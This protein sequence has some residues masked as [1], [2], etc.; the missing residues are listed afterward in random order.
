MLPSQQAAFLSSGGLFRRRNRGRWFFPR[1]WALLWLICLTLLAGSPNWPVS[2]ADPTFTPYYFGGA[3]ST[4]AVAVGDMNGDGRLDI[5]QGNDSYYGISLFLNDGLSTFGDATQVGDGYTLSAAVG[6]I[7]GDG[8]LDIVQGRDHAQNRVYLND[9]QGGFAA[10]IPFGSTPFTT[11]QSV[12]LGDFN[13][14]GALDI[15]EGNRGQSFLYLND[16][17]GGFGAGIPIG[18]PQDTRS[19]A[20]GDVNGDGALDIVMG[21]DNQPGMIYLND[22]LGGFGAGEPF[23]AVSHTARSV[24]VGDLNGDGALDIV[25]GNYGQQSFIYYNTGQGQFEVGVPLDVET[26]LTTSLVLGDVNGDGGLDIV[27][28]SE[29]VWNGQQWTEIK[30]ILYLNDGQGGFGAG[31]FIGEKQNARSLAVGDLNGDG[32]LDIVQGNSGQQSA[33]YVNLNQQDGFGIRFPLGGPSGSTLNLAV[34]D[35]NGDGALD[36]VVGDAWQINFYLNNQHG[37]FASGTGVSTAYL[38][39]IAIGDVNGDGALDIVQGNDYWED[40][41]HWL[42]IYSSPGI[43]Y[44]NTGQG[45]FVGSAFNP[46]MY[47]T[48]SIALGDLNGDDALDIV[49]GNRPYWSTTNEQWVGPASVINL[50]DGHSNFTASASFGWGKD[51][52]S[53]ALGDMNH[54]GALDIVQGN[55]GQP[56]VVYFND[57]QGRFE[58][59]LSFG[60]SY[61]TRSVAVGDLNGDGA[62]DIVQGNPWRQ[63]LIYWNSGWDPGQGQFERT[64]AFG[65][66]YDTRSI[67]IGDVNN[68]GAL[69]IVQGNYGSPSMIFLN[70]GLGGFG[71]GVSVGG[72]DKTVSLALGDLNGDGALDIVQGNEGQSYVYFNTRFR[73]AGLT[74]NPPAVTAT[75]PG[76]TR[77]AS[78]YSAPEIL[79][80]GIIPISYTLADPEGDAVG[81]VRAFYSLEGGGQWL[82]ARDA[83]SQPLTRCVSSNGLV[84]DWGFEEG[85]GALAADTSGNGYDLALNGPV[86]SD[87]T[88]ITLSYSAASLA[89]NNNTASSSVPTPQIDALQD[90][91]IALW[92]RPDTLPATGIARFITL[93]NEKAV[94]RSDHNEIHFYMNIGGDLRHLRVA[95]SLQPGVY[96][97]LAGSYD[98]TSRTMRLYYNGV[99]IASQSLAG[100][101]DGH[102]GDGSGVILG[103]FEEG[104]QGLVDEVRIYNRALLPDEI[105]ALVYNQDCAA[106]FPA[107]DAARLNRSLRF[108]GVDDFVALPDAAALHLADEMTIEAWV[109]LDDAGRDQKIV[110]KYVGSSGFILG[111]INGQLY[112][113]FADSA[114]VDY[115]FNAGE[116]GSIPSNE[117]T[118]LAVAWKTGDQIVAYIN[119]QAVYSTPA[120]ANPLAVNN[121]SI[122]I[123]A[124]SWMD[125][126]AGGQIDEVRLWSRALPAEEIAA[127]LRLGMPVNP[128]QM[129]GYWS[130]DEG[131]GSEVY[132]LSPQANHGLLAGGVRRP[133]WSGGAPLLPEG[134]VEASCRAVEKRWSL[135][136]QGDLPRFTLGSALN[137]DGVDDAV[138]VPDTAALNPTTFTI[139]AWI[140]ADTWAANNWEGTIVGKDGWS[141]GSRG[142]VL[143]SGDNGRLSAAVDCGGAWAGLGSLQLMTAGEWYH[144]AAAYNG[145]ELALFINGIPAG[146]IACTGSPIASSADLNI[147]RSPLSPDRLFAGQ[148]D[149]VRLWNYA[150]SAGQIRAAMR[151]A[152]PNATPGLIAS[153]RFNEGHGSAVFDQPPGKNYGTVVGATWESAA[154]PY[155]YY[156]DL[157]DGF[158]GQF[159]NIVFRLE[160]LPTSKAHAAVFPP[161]Y[162][163]SYSY[164]NSTPVFQHPSASATTFS[165]RMRGTQVRVMNG[166]SPAAGA[167][168]YR[169]EN[170]QTGR[171]QAIAPEAAFAGQAGPYLTDSQGYLLGRGE[172]LSGDQLT[173][174]WPAVVTDTYT[175]Y[176]TSAAPNDSGLEMFTLS[177]AGVQTLTV[178]SDNPLI[179]FNLDASLQWDARYDQ[180][181]LDQLERDFQRAAELLYDWTD[182]QAAL[183]SLRIYQNREHWNDAHIRIYASNELRPMAL[184]GGVV[185]SVISDTQNIKVAYAPGQVHLGAVWNRYGSAGSSLGE[186]WPRALAH[187]LGHYV[188]YLNDNYL[189]LA[190]G[191]VLLPVENCTGAMADPYREDLNYSEFHSQALW[192]DECSGTLSYQTTGRSDWETLTLFY[193]AL[194]SGGGLS[195]PNIL[196]IAVT[197]L[198]WVEPA[199]TSSPLTDPTFYLRQ[200]SEAGERLIPGAAARAFLFQQNWAID[201]GGVTQDHVL[202]R[203]AQPGD[204]LCVYDLPGQWA[205]CA[206]VSQFSEQIA[207]QKLDHWN[208]EVLITPVNSTTLQVSV[209]GVATENL[210]ASLYPFNE[211]LVLTRTLSTGVVT[212]HLA[213]P[214]WEGYLRI[215]DTANPAQQTIIDFAIGGNPSSIRG[216]SSSIR[217]S[218]SSIRGSSVPLLS[219]DGRVILFTDQTVL[220]ADQFY[221]LQAASSIPDPLSW[222]APV[223][224]VYRLAAAPASN[225]PDFSRAAISFGY[226]PLDVPGLAENR[227][228]LY[229]HPLNGGEWQLLP[230][231]VDEYNNM[232]SA[233]CQGQGWYALMSSREVSLP[234]AGW[235]LFA[236]SLERSLPVTDALRSLDGFYQ[237]IYGY[238]SLDV[239]DP[240][241]LHDVGV[242]SWVN[243][244]QTLEV[245]HG[246]WITVTQPVTLYLGY[247]DLAYTAALPNGD[248]PLGRVGW[249]GGEGVVNELPPATYYGALMGNGGFTP[250]A[251]MIIEAWVGAGGEAVFC[252]Q[253]VTQIVDGQVV[254]SIDVWAASASQPGCGQ[255]GRPVRFKVKD[256]AVILLIG[257]PVRS[258]LAWNNDRV[259]EV[260]LSPGYRIFLPAVSR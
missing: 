245:G 87:T 119:G 114:G 257:D 195:G 139:E 96:Q 187:E 226:N 35:V 188:F 227:L 176:Y 126:Y 160:A 104:Y 181:Y 158:F 209:S 16:K 83:I 29:S 69:D 72:N 133:R 153:W 2:A 130:F 135:S 53:I 244:L 131:W 256:Q 100:L 116:I 22:G 121:E 208:P 20:A 159:N 129:V 237:S 47:D 224:K 57:G 80:S 169:L 146:S 78:F 190:A 34:G 24:V 210:Q 260:T 205:G 243:D 171:A 150:R 103:A 254:Y 211:P 75:R 174:L 23:D 71:A 107:C 4:Y 173:A 38:Q 216:S 154:L 85:S 26:Y 198:E 44:T 258:D 62:L 162:G 137:F 144:V 249:G 13:G 90:L 97:H 247:P 168:V 19:V 15:L 91:T 167:T 82:P 65:G 193:P 156:W 94:L 128:R 228:R 7:N 5:I 79:S 52:T 199:N 36:I 98:S 151:A 46:E 101:P 225:P 246:Y 142:Y 231:Q 59:S 60:G 32:A 189:G 251:G 113:E 122:L 179:L 236:Y 233:P 124:A 255:P 175:L 48:T 92:I 230:T 184:Q 10:S 240:W 39:A 105:R 203:G 18:A 74:N 99:E 180:A 204:E 56:G 222:A 110:S 147:G 73:G 196:P 49:Q 6:D 212:F 170:G 218:S 102:V 111:V 3:A 183:G 172:L 220:R 177:A 259:W 202:A 200:G 132:D 63:S 109:K 214:V 117:W 58:K 165:F 55:E 229:Y 166:D 118:H 106:A 8:A 238:Y 81:A 112:P 28:G 157:A 194:E 182:G 70:D 197:Q 50:N 207:L 145:Q 252:G 84:G 186:D 33:I 201:L 51:T 250:Q 40:F 163:G 164:V 215:L 206:V 61:M 248:F 123:G 143:R 138:V 148:I 41:Y 125:Y 239:D 1:G 115:T 43:V 17:V 134:Q 14:D 31:G 242:P 217:G 234:S 45:G 64:T 140:K 149:E 88:P 21:V 54:D 161:A 120:S 66:T 235:N 232:A 253:G 136:P 178:S 152:L 191:G 67:A 223:G 219:A 25:Q 141:A 68:D 95:G 213:A 12:A 11:T 127:N 192:A 30:S 241:K 108:D 77:D 93:G 89:L 185:S 9:G 76:G 86:F 42:D 221:F 155:V 27:Q 37:A